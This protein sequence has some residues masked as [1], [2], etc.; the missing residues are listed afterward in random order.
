MTEANEFTV[1]LEDRLMARQMSDFISNVRMTAFGTF[2]SALVILPT[3]AKPEHAAFWIGWF[4]ALLVLDGSRVAQTF[5]FDSRM[6]DPAYNRKHLIVATL[7]ATGCGTNWAIGFV[8]LWQNAQ[9]PAEFLILCVLAAGIMSN[10]L[11]QY[12]Q[13]KVA[14]S[15][16]MI[17][18]IV[19]GTG[20][21][22]L[23]PIGLAA[24]ILILTW[25]H[26]LIILRGI[27][28]HAQFYRERLVEE[29]EL[30]RSEQTIRLLLHEYE[31]SASDWLW[32]MTADG[33]LREISS[34]FAE[35]AGRTLEELRE[36]QMLSLFREGPDRKVLE[37]HITSQKAFRDIV[38]QLADDEE[39]IWWSI[40][41]KLLGRGVMR[42][43]MSD[44]TSQIVADKKLF[45]MARSDPLTGLANRL[46]LSEALIEFSGGNA[47]GKSLLFIDLD[48][49]KIINDTIGHGAGDELLVA[50]AR[51]IARETNDR[52][53]IARLGGDEF[54]VLTLKS[55]SLDH[56]HQLA[57]RLVAAPADPFKIAGRELRVSASVGVAF[58]EQEYIE[59]ED[60]MRRADLAL[61]AAKNAG[62]SCR[63]DYDSQLHSAE[64]DRRELELDLRTALSEG[65]FSLAFQAQMDIQN[66]KPS[67]MEAL[68]RWNHPTRGLIMPSE[69]I[70]L[71]EESG[72]IISIGEWIIRDALRQAS[73][74]AEPL[75][76]ALNL[77]PVQIRSDRLVTVLAQA[78]AS[79]G[80]APERIE[81]EVT[82]TALLHDTK[83]NLETLHK[84]HAL[85]VR[86]ALDD[87][88]T[89]YSS[90]SYLR[91][92][93]FDTV[94]IDRCFVKELSKR[95]DC[96]A[97]V[98]SI[99]GLAQELGMKTIA[100]GIETLEQHDWL[101]LVGCHEGQ[102]YLIS[103][104]TSPCS[105]NGNG[106][107]DVAILRP[108]PE[109]GEQASEAEFSENFE[110]HLTTS[111]SLNI[112]HA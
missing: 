48:K 112:R 26:G 98:K 37:N 86:V 68:I 100:E 79:S 49:F 35:A 19:A 87:F 5:I 91:R 25:L 64:L 109:E 21:S 61:Y 11:F 101:K 106:L 103:R 56:A 78:I 99:V 89:G 27:A 94:K 24:P 52:E 81:L 1:E 22:F 107:E 70:Q 75:T 108:N 15:A 39:E 54:A 96:Q 77:S 16:L 51:R 43:V 95:S 82:E 10:A 92:F 104:P 18:C 97:I 110:H 29:F 85:G 34:R 20:I 13:L 14:S 59:P 23:F 31:E 63:R 28:D 62:R 71:A 50:V 90:L 69:F 4:C 73:L 36:T 2:V 45:G 47:R 6:Q 76:V 40:S 9:S 105:S 111:A 3:L 84:L 80:I 44:V 57:D 72:S 8:V 93:P 46:S 42:G 60:W 67:G 55:T 66:G 58:C 88:G 65:Q 53:L 102:G 30:E 7:L 33:S 17:S 74:W 32:E 12:R 38:V 83:E 41:A